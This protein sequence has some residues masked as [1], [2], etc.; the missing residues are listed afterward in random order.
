MPMYDVNS[1]LIIDIL[2][3]IIVV[4]VI[5]GFDDISCSIDYDDDG[6]VNVLDLISMINIILE[7]NND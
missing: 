2:D 4:N 5:L 6:V 1:D 7:Q 3:I